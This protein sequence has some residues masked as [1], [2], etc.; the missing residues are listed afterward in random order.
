MIYTLCFLA[1]FF[2]CKPEQP[3]DLI[4]SEEVI[5]DY[6][7]IDSD[8]V[9]VEFTN[10]A[11]LENYI[12]PAPEE[13]TIDSLKYLALGDSYTIG[14]SVD[15]LLRWPVQLASLIN[16]NSEEHFIYDPVIIAQT[17]WTTANLNGAM[18]SQ[19]IDNSEFDLVSLLI[20]VNNQFQG[21][22]LEQYEIE[23][24]ALL[25]RAISLAGDNPAQVFVVSIP[26]YGYTPF[27]VGNQESIS[28]DLATFNEA[29]RQITL[30]KNV[31]H[32]NI[33][34]ISQQWP[35]IENLIASDNLHPSGYQY[36]LWAESFFQQVIE[37][38]LP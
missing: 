23:Y 11:Q 6:G 26:D 28:T 12:P 37:N 34:P 32:Y 10:V 15:P 29:C 1:F 3:D 20:G 16:Q 14:Q 36:Q 27:G 4:S 18:D 21:L 31:S 33:T 35:E 17:G 19:N 24:E 8:S 38:D 30:S 22:S 9:Y 25:D 7:G 13:P 2:S 5:I